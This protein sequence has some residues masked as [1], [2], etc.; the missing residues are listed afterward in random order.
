M[1]IQY[2]NLI[3][4]MGTPQVVGPGI[5]GGGAVHAI[6]D[7]D[8][9][10]RFR[11]LR[12]AWPDTILADSMVGQ[13]EV[14]IEDPSAD[15]APPEIFERPRPKKPRRHL[16]LV[17]PAPPAAIRVF[18]PVVAQRF[19]GLDPA[20][21]VLVAA[22]NSIPDA[23]SV[24]QAAVASLAAPYGIAPLGLGAGASAIVPAGTARGLARLSAD[25]VRRADRVVPIGRVARI[26]RIAKDR[27]PSGER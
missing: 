11:G 5:A 7:R 13:P 27:K 12:M 17:P 14:T 4:G 10:P 22:P 9:D 1:L 21:A 18:G 6:R 25:L 15:E 16:A 2:R 23:A 24:F 19:N 3:L 8:P 20:A 26:Q